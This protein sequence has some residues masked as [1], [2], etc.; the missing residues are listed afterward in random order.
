MQILYQR[1]TVGNFNTTQSMLQGAQISSR[2][3][4]N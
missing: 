1:Q 3:T 4:K 2:W